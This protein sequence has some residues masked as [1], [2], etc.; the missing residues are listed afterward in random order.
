MRKRKLLIILILVLFLQVIS[1]LRLQAAPVLSNLVINEEIK[2]GPDDIYLTATG[3]YSDGGRQ[4]I[5]SG[6]NWLSSNNGIVEMSTGGRAH[7]TGKGGPVTIT[8]YLDGITASKTLA[9]KPWPVTLDIE[10]TLVY[11]ENP[12][13]LAV[14]GR[15]SDGEERYYGPED[16]LQWFTS[17]PWV[18]WVN[19]QGVVSF[20]GE[21][22][23]VSIKAAW[24]ILSDSVNTTVNREDEPTVFHK[25]IKIKEEIKY[26]ALP[27]KLT[28]IAVS[29]D[30]TEE[31]L[32]GEAADWSSSNTEVAAASVEGVLTFTGKPGVTEIKVSYGGFHYTVNVAVARAL[33]SIRLNQSLNYTPGWLKTGKQLSVTAHYNDGTEE[34]TSKGFAWEI[35]NK[36]VAAI[37]ADGKLTFTGKAG[38]VTV[39][40]S[41]AVLDGSVKSDTA[42]LVV[43]ETEAA[44]PQR[45]YIDKN[46]VST[47]ETL[48][49]HVLCIYDDGNI[50]DVT[51][52]VIWNSGNDQVSIWEGQLYFS[53]TPGPIQV[54]ANFKGLTDEITGYMPK[55]PASAGRV[56]QLRIKEHKTLFSFKPVQLTGSAVMGDG[57]VRDVTGSLRW[58]SSNSLVA[59][60]KKGV[61]TFTGK[62][63]QTVIT[64][65]GY[66]MRDK[67]EI[68]VKPADLQ[69]RAEKLTIEGEL[70]R[71]INQLQVIALFNNGT[72]K[73]VTKEVI[74][75][76]GNRGVAIVTSDG[77]V[78]FPDGLKPVT[79]FANYQELEASISRT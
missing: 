35:D 34:Q 33:E 52:E 62:P 13:R 77:A 76:T 65:Q 1:T 39:K 67:L 61:L 72:S 25:G 58:S 66:G 29:N 43:P 32:N 42:T 59:G 4:I 69:P 79:I 70:N 53:P 47:G 24:S 75:N 38:K 30:D 6:L 9:V 18:A 28:L 26:T 31:T 2:P 36:K 11:S 46:P 50:R 55:L 20:T 49:P 19:S 57:S 78:L 23:Y 22:G 14:K 16:G 64:A 51:K 3:V 15:F 37:T 27:Q 12:Y 10:T 40:V 7:F 45:L 54:T 8:V 73:D 21:N 68:E 56:Y 5:S 44:L 17:D 60:V 48:S 63:G 41:A 71:G 74:W